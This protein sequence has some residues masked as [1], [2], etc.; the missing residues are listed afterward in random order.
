VTRP[1][2]ERGY[3]STVR[4]RVV[5][6]DAGETLVHPAPSFP[7]LFSAVLAGEG[8]VRAPDDVVEAAKVVLSRFSEAARDRDLWT[9][10]PERSRQFWT[11]VYGRMLE[12]LD[13][14]ADHLPDRLYGAFTDL[15]N[16]A[17]FADV[18]SAFA[19]LRSAGITLGVVSNFEAWL[20]DLLGVLGV[21]DDLP[22]RAISGL[23][24]IE[25]PDPRIYELALE[26]A[27]VTAD[28]AAFVGDNPEFDV[29]PPAS[30]GMF[31]VLVDRNR[32]HPEFDGVRVEA[33]TELPA[34][35]EAAG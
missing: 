30:L 29:D 11:G 28:E 15:T 23:E 20:E 22:V 16:Y 17:L 32:R 10:S 12:T 18:E 4:F 35:L 6:F 27:G 2:A 21:S 31:P 33:L 14:R 26:R 8:H 9:T 24:G 3:P 19:S 25:K 13:L 34:V 7:E 1:A 5:L